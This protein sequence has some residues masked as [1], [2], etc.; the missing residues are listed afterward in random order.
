[1]F[2]G[3]LRDYRVWAV[4]VTSLILAACRA[5]P[6]PPP[7]ATEILEQSAQ[8]MSALRSA[9]F[10]IARAGAP[11]YVDATQLFVFRRAEGDFVAP[12]SARATVRVIGPAL[13]TE[14]SVVAIGDQYWET[15]PLSGEWVNYS[16]FGYNPASLFNA[17]SGLAALMQNDLSDVSWVGLEELEDLPGERLFHLTASAPGQA[18]LAMTANLVGRGPVLFD[19]WIEP[20][21]YHVLRLRVTEPETDPADPTVWLIDF[22]RFDADLTIDPP[23]P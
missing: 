21:T 23:L 22:D 19:W 9:H 8:A 20:E 5:T 14:V 16:G 6:T 2:M 4:F 3:R 7:P 18:V 15:N 17:D 10:V 1:M 12:D 11:A 13:V